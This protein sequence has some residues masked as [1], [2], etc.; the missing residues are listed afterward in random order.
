ML[1]AFSVIKRFEERN[2]RRGDTTGVFVP[3]SIT[4]ESRLRTPD[5]R[6]G[7]SAKAN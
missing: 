1:S 7:G 2:G 3:S 6:C 5:E 4:V